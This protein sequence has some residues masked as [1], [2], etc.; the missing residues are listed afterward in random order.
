MAKLLHM[1]SRCAASMRLSE[2]P[3]SSA[4]KWYFSRE[5]IENYSPSRKDGIDLGRE[6][7]L[8]KSYCSFIQELGMKLKVPQVAIACAMMLCHRFYM[9]QSHAKNDWQTIATVSTFL[10]CKIEETPRLLRDVIV[11]AYEII[12]K[13][14]PSAPGRIRQRE[15]F[16]KQKEL[17]LTGERLLLATIAFDLDIQLPYKPLVAAVKRLEIFPNLLKVAWNFVN[18]WLRTTLCLQYKPHYIAAGS[19]CLA[20][21]FQK[22]KLPMEKGKVWWLE[23]DISPKQLQEVTQ[24]MV[25]LLERDKERA[26]SSR[27]ERAGQSVALAGKAII[28]GTQSST[29][30]AS[31][32]KDQS[33][34]GAENSK[35]SKSLDSCIRD[36]S[37]KEVLPHQ[38][39]DSGASSVVEDGTDK[40]QQRT[41]VS[42][43]NSSFK[44][45]SSQVCG[46]NEVSAK[47]NVPCQTSD[48]GASTVVDNGEG[49]CELRTEESDLNPS[50]KIVSVHNTFSKSDADQFRETLKR[51]RCDRA[52]NRKCVGGIEDEADSEAT[53]ESDRS[54]KI[55]SVRNTFS[56]NDA[57]RIRETLKRRRCDRAANRKYVRGIDDETNSEAWIERELE[58]GIELEPTSSHKQRRA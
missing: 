6:E 50:F 41:Q 15:V 28:S 11:V 17:I 3:G 2:Q 39:S 42:D 9:R 47:E 23:F 12:Y 34:T 44:I 27:H 35:L 21:K 46:D 14:D 56:K 18:D 51:R 43:L 20:A 53:E 36:V 1:D 33:G 40:D 19:M 45:V 55:V 7:Q 4:R 26:L 8:R 30:A 31:H 48:S 24:Q 32:A 10:A 37:M 52:A 57:N 29:L 16:D 22:V 49:E 5:E 13:R 54:F 38:R 58:N 25:R